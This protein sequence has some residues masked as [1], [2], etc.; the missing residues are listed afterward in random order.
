MQVSSKL[1]S[2]QLTPVWWIP[3][4]YTVIHIFIMGIPDQSADPALKVAGVF[5][6][7]VNWG[8]TQPVVMV[9]A[10]QEPL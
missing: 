10:F 4:G 9:F 5:S 6:N 3:V 1:S 8:T 7:A 2:A